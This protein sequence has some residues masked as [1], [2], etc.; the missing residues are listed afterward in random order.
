M[1]EVRTSQTLFKLTSIY[2]ALSFN[3]ICIS[4]INLHLYSSSTLVQWNYDVITMELHVQW[5]YV[6][7]VE[8]DGI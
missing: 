3:A 4:I 5:K 6:P 8:C 7:R 1:Y 2:G